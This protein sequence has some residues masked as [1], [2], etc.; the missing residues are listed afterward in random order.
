MRLKFVIQGCAALAVVLFTTKTP[1]QKTLAPYDLVDPFVG[2]GGGGNTF[3]GATL[4]FG[5]VQWSPD[6]DQDGWYRHDEKTMYGLSLTHVSGAGCPLYGDFA[7]L[8]VGEALGVS[9]GADIAAFALG[10]DRKSEVAHPGYYAVTLA[11]GVRVEITVAERAGIA[12]FRF[13]QGGSARLLVNAGSSTHGIVGAD[14]R[15]D[16]AKDENEIALDGQSG[17]GGWSRAGHFCSSNSHYKI[18]AAGVFDK[19]FKSSALWQDDAILKDA[20][21]ARGAATGAWLDFG[22]VREVT[23]KVGVSFVSEDGAR[24]NMGKEIAGRNFDAVA[25]NARVNWEALLNRFASQGGTDE[26][27]T[28]FYTGVYHSFLSPNLFSDEDAQYVGFDGKIHSVAGTRQKAQYA[29]Y[30][31]WDIYR[32]T[33]Q[34][35]AL[36]FPERSSD[37]MQSLVNDA[38]QSGRL[39]RWAAAN[40]VTDVMGGD[41]PGPV[42]ASAYAFGARNFDTENALKYLVKA[43]TQT[44]GNQERPFLKEYLALGYVP[45]EKDRIA[46]SR[47]LE[48]ASD[49]FAIAEFAR[50]LGHDDVAGRF[51]KQSQSWR[52]LLDPQSGW[53]RPRLSDGSWLQGFDAELSLPKGN[54]T[55][56]LGFEE[57][58]TYQYTFMIPFDY[59]ALFAGIGGEAKVMPRLDS[60]FKGLRCWGKPCYNIENE[61]DFVAPFAYVFAGQPWKMQEVVSRIGKETFKATPDGIPGNDDLGATSG[62]YV[63]NAL[64]FYPAVPGV[65][66]LV[67]GTPM[68]DRVT[69]RLGGGRTVDIRRSGKGIYVKQMMLNGLP[70]ANQW[71][72]LQ[73]LDAGTTEILF[74]MQETPDTQRGTS[75]ADR[76][77]SFREEH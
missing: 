49:D 29:N 6:T 3:P 24:A 69:L 47:T 75:P 50:A 54:G 41:S 65:G 22:D 57:G 70:Y 27:R 63:W 7:V 44:D 43:G 12:R 9:P 10:F 67:V 66:G 30:S 26:Q 48:Y 51:F 71:L 4:P 32:N 2:T 13:P 62:V 58:N 23:L 15:K 45:S 20:H 1:A 42:I 56:Q 21:A 38:E 16:A 59:P 76:P 72:A 8:P 39:P 52:N 28:I 40:D 36:F 34:L 77:P 19:P 74:T 37:M 5:M 14:R 25:R 11:S 35:Q 46:A 53:I 60:F 73:K 55:D 64:G 18:Y 61:P 17:F 33:V 31:D 68:F